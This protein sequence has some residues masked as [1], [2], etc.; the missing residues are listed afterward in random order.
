MTPEEYAAEVAAEDELAFREVLSSERGQRVLRRIAFRWCKLLDQAHTGADASRDFI[1][2]QR[3]IGRAIVE[4]C[5][6]VDALR[7]IEFWN[8]YAQER[9][10]R[11][12]HAVR[13]EPEGD[14][15]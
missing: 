4:E 15:A 3:S 1:D 11:Q 12:T 10:E 5:F 13:V 7:A 8:G 14:G 9:G 2:G 6:R